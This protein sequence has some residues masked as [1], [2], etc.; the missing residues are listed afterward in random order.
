MRRCDD[1]LP[2]LPTNESGTT[3]NDDAKC[4]TDSFVLRMMLSKYYEEWLEYNGVRISINFS[5][6]QFGKGRKLDAFV[7]MDS[8]HGSK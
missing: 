8:F 3:V 6:R 7:F 5:V 4:S 1:D 2:E